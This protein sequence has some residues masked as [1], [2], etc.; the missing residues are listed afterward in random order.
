MGFVRFLPQMT[1]GSLQIS[2]QFC[3]GFI[4]A[5]NKFCQLMMCRFG[6]KVTDIPYESW[7][8]LFTYISRTTY[9]RLAKC[10]IGRDKNHPKTDKIH[11]Y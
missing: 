9:P 2:L 6:N 3:D 5:N 10:I 7:S 11:D 4:S 8:Q 1:K